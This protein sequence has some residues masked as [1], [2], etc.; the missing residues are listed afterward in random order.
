MQSLRRSFDNGSHQQDVTG[1]ACQ[2][3]RWAALHRTRRS[4]RAIP[5]CNVSP[6]SG[7]HP[8]D[9]IPPLRHASKVLSGIWVNKGVCLL[10]QD[11]TI[12]GSQNNS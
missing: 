11:A 4:S 10:L 8:A 2:G 1:L 5:P 3:H 6:G 12:L 9:C 7:L